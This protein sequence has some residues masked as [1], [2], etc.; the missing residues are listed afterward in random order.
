MRIRVEKM[1]FVQIS[2]AL[3]MPDC[4]DAVTLVCAPT[5]EKMIYNLEKASMNKNPIF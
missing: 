1:T 2:P 4:M 5:V 3:P